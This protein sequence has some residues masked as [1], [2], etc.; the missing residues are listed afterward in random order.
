MK[1]CA[2]SWQNWQQVAEES[3]GHLVAARL[4]EAGG[5]RVAVDEDG[6]EHSRVLQHL[7]A[8]LSRA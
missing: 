7:R 4:E 5:R 2:T 6:A 3:G 8:Q 1:L